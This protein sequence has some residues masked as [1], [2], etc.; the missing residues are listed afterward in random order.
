MISMNDLKFEIPSIIENG[1]TS[2]KSIL[3][4]RAQENT[5]SQGKTS[6]DTSDGYRHRNPNLCQIRFT[7]WNRGT[8]G[9]NHNFKLTDGNTDSDDD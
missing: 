2:S 1:K 4:R 6:M 8:F 9:H 7:S 3:G 5:Y